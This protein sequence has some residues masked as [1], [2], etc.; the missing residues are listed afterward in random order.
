MYWMNF[1]FGGISVLVSGVAG[2]VGSLA[3]GEQWVTGSL[4]S[5]GSGVSS[6]AVGEVGCLSFLLALDACHPCVS[7]SDSGEPQ[8]WCSFYSRCFRS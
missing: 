7:S 2:L 3:K 6:Q 1:Y 8:S 4:P 5:T